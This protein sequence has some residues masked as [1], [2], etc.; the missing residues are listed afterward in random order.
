VNAVVLLRHASA[1]DRD[2]WP[3][4]DDERPLDK[5][6]RRQAKA[7]V[8]EFAHYEFG[9]IVS[10]PAVRCVQTVEPLAERLGLDIEARDELAEGAR[11]EEA[12]ALVAEVRGSGAVLCTHGDVVV[13]LLGAGLK[14]GR[15]ALLEP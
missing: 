8:E 14:K 2:D 13:E 6:G 1:G 15:A 4:E 5:K 7:L 3:G 12:L 10:S 11:R 9:R